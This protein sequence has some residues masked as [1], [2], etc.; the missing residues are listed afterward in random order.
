MSN[1]IIQ[2]SGTELEP[3]DWLH[4]KFK[5]SEYVGRFSGVYENPRYGLMFRLTF[6]RRVDEPERHDTVCCFLRPEN[7][8]AEALNQAVV[9]EKPKLRG[10]KL[11]ISPKI[12]EGA[13]FH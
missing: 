10:G 3:G 9:I 6:A 2:T 12:P 7:G 1:G 4:I 11:S 13:V 5:D 8:C